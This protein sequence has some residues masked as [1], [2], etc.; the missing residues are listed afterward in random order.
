MGGHVVRHHVSRR[1]HG[2]IHCYTR[3]LQTHVSKAERDL[4]NK[5]DMHQQ[6]HYWRQIT[7]HCRDVPHLTNGFFKSK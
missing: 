4:I 3:H 2:A 7:K 6:P 5:R 1:V